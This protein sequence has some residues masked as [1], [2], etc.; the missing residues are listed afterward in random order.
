MPRECEDCGCEERLRKTPDGTWRCSWCR[1]HEKD[2]P[3][4][5]CGICLGAMDHDATCACRPPK[6]KVTR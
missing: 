5:R 1:L 2:A 3:Y 6:V 4:G